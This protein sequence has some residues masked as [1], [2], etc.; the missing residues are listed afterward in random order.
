MSPTRPLPTLSPVTP[1][2][3]RCADDAVQHQDI[4]RDRIDLV[5]RQRLR[6]GLEGLTGG[7]E[8]G[9]GVG[10][11]A[12][13]VVGLDELLPAGEVACVLLQAVGE[14]LHHALDHLLAISHGQFFGCRDVLGGRAARRR[15]R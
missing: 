9:N 2:K 6:F 3:V 1:E 15:R 14:T 4:G 13:R 10:L 8:G 7:A 12:H 11:A 5:G